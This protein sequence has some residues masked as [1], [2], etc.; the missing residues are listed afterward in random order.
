MCTSVCVHACA[1]A[2][3]IF[4]T[5]SPAIWCLFGELDTP[6]LMHPN[7]LRHIISRNEGLT[8]VYAP[9]HCTC[10]TLLV[11]TAARPVC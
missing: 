8:V 7:K 3:E 10:V 11:V 5:R 2:V 9:P 1:R 4:I 6:L